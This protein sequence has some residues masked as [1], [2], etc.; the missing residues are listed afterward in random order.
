MIDF[1]LAFLYRLDKKYPAIM[2]E[3]GKREARGEM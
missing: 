2:A 3:L 1:T